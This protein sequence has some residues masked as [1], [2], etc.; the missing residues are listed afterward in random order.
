MLVLTFPWGSVSPTN[1]GLL[2]V[3]IV[4]P[5]SFCVPSTLCSA[6]CSVHFWKW[7]NDRKFSNPRLLP[8]RHRAAQQPPVTGPGSLGI[9]QDCRRSWEPLTYQPGWSWISNPENQNLT[10]HGLQQSAPG[11]R[12]SLGKWP[13]VRVFSVIDKPPSWGGSTCPESNG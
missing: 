1:V 5:I 13:V 6:G 9:S 2:K 12:R 8:P 4:S 3:E 11:G 10:N 7:E